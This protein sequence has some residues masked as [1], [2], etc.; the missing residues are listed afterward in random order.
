MTKAEDD[1]LSTTA[2]AR[3]LDIPVQQL[4]AAL[5]DYG[6]INRVDNAWVLT[7]KGEFEG[8]EY[9]ESKRYGR[10]IVWPKTLQHHALVVAI[11]DSQRLTTAGLAKRFDLHPRM[12]SRALAELGLQAHTILGW[13][14]TEQ[15]KKFGGL[16]EESENSG[17][18][19]VS[20]PKDIVENPV[21]HRELDTLC[22]VESSGELASDSNS[23]DRS[24]D[25]FA[26][27]SVDKLASSDGHQLQTQLELHVCN[28]LYLAQLAHA[29]KRRLPVEDELLADFY[30]PASSVYIECWQEDIEHEVL[31][32]KLRK[33][34]M[35]RIQQLKVID[36]NERDIEKLDKVLGDSLRELGIRC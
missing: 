11:E 12:V 10:Y 30:L 20:W 33:Q 5:K 27:S 8:G 24:G 14:L 32:N 17:T 19:Y 28:W 3:A 25:L 31:S 4:F 6:W 1:K 22:L 2:V 35:Y 13:E 21:I 9:R 26:G 7:S 18:L 36:I 29:Y 15:G 16:Q 23:G 34:E